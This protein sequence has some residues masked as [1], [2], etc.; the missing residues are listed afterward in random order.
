MILVAMT[1]KLRGLGDIGG[2]DLDDW[3]VEGIG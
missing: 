2:Y 3:T 1:G